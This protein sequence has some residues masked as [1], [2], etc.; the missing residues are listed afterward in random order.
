[1]KKGWYLTE[2][3]GGNPRGGEYQ[4]AVNFSHK[5]VIIAQNVFDILR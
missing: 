5:E 3:G 2:E 4:E 1:M